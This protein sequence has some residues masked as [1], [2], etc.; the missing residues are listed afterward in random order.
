MHARLIATVL[1]LAFASAG[2]ALTLDGSGQVTDWNLTPNLATTTN[3]TNVVTGGVAST[4]AND[5]APINYPN[6][7]YSPSGGEQWD[8]EEMH[9]RLNGL[10]QL[11][12]L[13]VNT[14]GLSGLYS[15]TTI[16]LG[17]LFITLDNQRYGVV[18]NN[19][20]Q[21]L[22]AGSVYRI[23]QASDVQ[24]LQNVGPSY[25]GNNTSVA[26]DY[27]PNDVI[28]NV[29]GPWAIAST[30]DNSQLIGA[31]AMVIATYNYGGDEDGTNL[32]EYTINTN[33][34]APFTTFAARQ[35]YGCGNDVIEVAGNRT[36]IPEPASLALMGIGM[37][38]IAK[39]TRRA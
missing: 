13:V 39:R 15:G 36:D 22:A 20:S 14:S 2:F 4:F 27:G 10:G 1:S 6:V 21:G 34:F 31:A 17:D 32:I 24:L 11:Q 3:Q 25:F 33:L 35:T 9:V 28:R 5:Y 38:M 19:A 18:T 7:G 26:N 29:A 30:I 37:M 8:I 16:Y 12:V 23:D